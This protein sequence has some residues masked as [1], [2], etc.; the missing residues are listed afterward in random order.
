MAVAPNG[1]ETGAAGQRIGGALA[2]LLVGK[3][4]VAVE[5]DAG[6]N[7]A[8]VHRDAANLGL[9]HRAA[10]GEAQRQ[11]RDCESSLARIVSSSSPE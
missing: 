1:S 10:G 6:G 11:A 5:R 7:T 8:V 3:A 9:C 2:G 4:H